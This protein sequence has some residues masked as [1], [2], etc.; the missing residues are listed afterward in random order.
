MQ[1]LW[2]LFVIT[3]KKVTLCMSKINN[4]GIKTVLYPIKDVAQAKALYSELLG[5]APYVDGP[6]YVGF[7]IGDQ[8]VGLVPNGHAQGMKGTTAYHQVDDIKKSL[9]LILDAG[10]QVQQD[11]RDVGG[12]RQVATAK[13]ADGNII[14]LMQDS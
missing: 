2:Y 5:V 11:V 6:Y 8:Q 9:Q 3:S 7:K 13:D 4:Q 1:K 10:G 14:G 12:G